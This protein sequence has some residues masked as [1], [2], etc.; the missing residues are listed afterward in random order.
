MAIRILQLGLSKGTVYDIV[1]KNLYFLVYKL[2]LIGLDYKLKL[3]TKTKGW[4]FD[5]ITFPHT[6]YKKHFKIKLVGIFYIVYTL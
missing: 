1:G 3:Q 5:Y 4:S 2:Q 6:I